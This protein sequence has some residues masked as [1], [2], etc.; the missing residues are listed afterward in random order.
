MRTNKGLKPVWK[1]E[2]CDAEIR[3]WNRY[4]HFEY[5]NWMK[6][7]THNKMTVCGKMYI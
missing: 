4:S 5:N 2:L 7:Q 1:K 3:T 6:I